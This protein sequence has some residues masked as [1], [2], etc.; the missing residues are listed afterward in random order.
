MLEPHPPLINVREAVSRALLEDL[1][2]LGDMTAALLPI[3]LIATAVFCR[4][5]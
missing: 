3:D 4:A 1:A 2:P 5:G